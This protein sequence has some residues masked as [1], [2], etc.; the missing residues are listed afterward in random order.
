MVMIVGAEALALTRLGQLLGDIGDRVLRYLICTVHDE[1][2]QSLPES[3]C[4]EHYG[5][6]VRSLHTGTLSAEEITVITIWPH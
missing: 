2:L 6:V 3:F 1:Q 4:R 5:K